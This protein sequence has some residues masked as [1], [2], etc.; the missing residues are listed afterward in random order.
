MHKKLL[1]ATTVGDT[2]AAILRGQPKWLAKH[3]DVALMTSP[4]DFCAQIA[5]NEGIVP[6]LVPMARRIS[7]LSDLR[8]IFLAYREISRLRP[9]IIHS[10]TPKAGLVIMVAAC[11]A[12]VPVRIHSFTGLLFP[13]S[14]GMKRLLLIWADRLICG[15]ATHVIAE[16]NGVARDLSAAKITA[17]RL[18][19]LANGNVAGVDPSYYDRGAPGVADATSKVKTRFRL[20][21]QDLVIGYVGRLTPDKGLKDLVR[22]M[23]IVNG[24]LARS[25]GTHCKLICVGDQDASAPLPVDTKALLT[26]DPH[27]I[28]T[29]W[30]DDIRPYLAIMDVLILPSLREGFPNVL[31]QGG[32]M[33]VPLIAT[34]INGSNEIVI[35]NETGLLVPP[36]DI[37]ALS[38]AILTL[39]NSTPAERARMGS[40]GRRRVKSLFSQAVVRDALL[41]FYLGVS[42]S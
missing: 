39:L 40:Q 4:G 38:D 12:R 28:L 3:F 35:Q 41:N 2:L 17:K 10:Y 21:T 30:Q 13:T 37:H 29:G 22:A 8:S 33:S 25:S 15:S 18:N 31:L 9:D 19:V 14:R 20:T 5:E 16:G 24:S 32:A 7:P 27:V 26:N 42:A 23:E 11:L 36:R 34:D 1:I 6:V